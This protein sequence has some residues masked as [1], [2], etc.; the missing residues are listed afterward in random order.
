[1][2]GDVQLVARVRRLR[3]PGIAAGL[4]LLA[5]GSSGLVRADGGVTLGRALTDGVTDGSS[6]NIQF[7]VSKVGA[8]I[9]MS[10]PQLA[11][12]SSEPV[13]IVDVSE[14]PL[15]AGAQNTGW[16]LYK[17]PSHTVYVAF[18]P[19][20][21]GAEAEFAQELVDVTKDA[22]T[23]PAHTTFGPDLFLYV[24]FVLTSPG[25]YKTDYIKVTYLQGG[26]LHYQKFRDGFTFG[27]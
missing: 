1:M 14:T 5:S 13:T 2:A 24:R 9:F 3:T 12:T 8:P 25:Q 21:G 19:A 20:D 17:V 26:S 6:Y 22:K 16:V 11:N 7:G 15:G 23:I 10:G 18:S 4:L 27:T